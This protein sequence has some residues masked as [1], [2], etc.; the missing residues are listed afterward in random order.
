MSEDDLYRAAIKGMLEHVD[1]G[2]Q[3]WNTLLSP[4]EVAALTADL[5]GEVVGIGAE[6]HID[7]ASGYTDVLGVFPGSPAEKAGLASGDKILDIDGKPL[8]GK[9]TKDILAEIRGKAG[10]AVALSI[11]RDDKLFTVSV[12]REVVAYDVVRAFM[13]PESVGYLRV[14]SFN[15]KTRP[16]IDQ[17][18]TDLAARSAR[19][20]VVDLRGNPGGGFDDAVASAEAWVP[21]GATIVK[22]QHRGEASKSFVAKGPA[23]LGDAPMAVL[24]DG[25]TSSGGE[26]VAVALV[27]ARHAVAVG[28]KTFGKWTVQMLDELPNGY[29]A[30]YTV[31]LFRSATDANYDGVGYKPDVEVDM[32]PKQE[33]AALHE[34]DVT[35]RLALDSQLRTA[36]ALLRRR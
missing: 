22:T 35:K 24:V 5:H 31:S 6:I 3:K 19:A 12:V 8:R 1:P 15:A 13:L 20:L 28:A 27:D 23:T 16:A 7:D 10:E 9:T 34:T 25:E 18:M 32:D 30:K 14:R 33:S 36:V 17:A 29:A 4:D 26:F 11:L 21:R 2:H